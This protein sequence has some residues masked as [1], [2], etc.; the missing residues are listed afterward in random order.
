MLRSAEQ[1]AYDEIVTAHVAVPTC[2]Q[3][4]RFRNGSNQLD[5]VTLS[6]VHSFTQLG[7]F[8]LRLSRTASRRASQFASAKRK[9]PLPFSHKEAARERT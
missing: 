8:N 5:E 6:I 1:S 9:A 4:Q 2:T 3:N 7:H